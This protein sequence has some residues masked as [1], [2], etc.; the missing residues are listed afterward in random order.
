MIVRT[1]THLFEHTYATHHNDMIKKGKID[2]F[3]Y[4]KPKL[5]RLNRTKMYEMYT[6]NIYM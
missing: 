1:H 2:E 6:N 3:Q 4:T 5:F